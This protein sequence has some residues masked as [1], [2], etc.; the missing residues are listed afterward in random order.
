MT[1]YLALVGVIQFSR[2]VREV[3][4]GFP[5][6]VL[7]TCKLI[8]DAMVC[9]FEVAKFVSRCYLLSV[10]G[11]WQLRLVA[12]TSCWSMFQGKDDVDL[13]MGL[14]NIYAQC[15]DMPVSL[16]CKRVSFF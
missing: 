11:T 13:A 8:I 10:A 1:G 14:Q 9:V 7:D 12:I 15:R 2:V 5:H 3:I 4:D 6:R 16:V